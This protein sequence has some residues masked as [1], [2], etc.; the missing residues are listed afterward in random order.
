MFKIVVENGGPIWYEERQRSGHDHWFSDF[1]LTLGYH[2][3]AV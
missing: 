3:S 2:L 1:A